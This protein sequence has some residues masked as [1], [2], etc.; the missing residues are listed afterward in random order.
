M[1]LINL[2][3]VNA[4]VFS[5]IL[6][7]MLLFLISSPKNKHS[8]NKIKKDLNSIKRQINGDD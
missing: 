2:L 3:I 6:V 8:K 1:N 5:T 4:G 7:T